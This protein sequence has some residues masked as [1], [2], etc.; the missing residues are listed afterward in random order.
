MMQLYM[1]RWQSRIILFAKYKQITRKKT[2]KKSPENFTSLAITSFE[3][4]E[5]K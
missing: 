4:L 5:I 3:R 1:L 2:H